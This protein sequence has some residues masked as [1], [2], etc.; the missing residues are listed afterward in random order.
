L[1]N[2]QKI[3]QFSALTASAINNSWNEVA[4]IK[5]CIN[6][7][8]QSQE[9]LYKHFYPTMMAMVK[10]YTSD[11][12]HAATIL[13]NGFL[14]VFKKIS[15]FKN[16][17]SLEGWIRRIVLRA[18]ADFFREKKA[19]TTVD[20]LATEQNNLQP[21]VAMHIPYDY[22]LLIQL[23]QQLPTATR[24]VINLFMI[25]GYTHKEIA[26]LLAIS[27]NTSKWHVAEGKKILI[28][29]LNKQQYEY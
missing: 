19:L 9:Q 12:H 2:E 11:T 28:N 13:N 20:V 1:I 29:L 6:N 15:Q 21:T 7:H 14:K 26:T 3:T 5:G 22:N 10:R 27:E 4:C 18:V 25:E 24:L 16:E 8:L 23:L 17:G